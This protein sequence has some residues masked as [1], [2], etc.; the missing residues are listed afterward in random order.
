MSGRTLYI[1]DGYNVL[2]RWFPGVGKE[3]LF[4]RREWLV[5]RLAEL[6]AVR[7]ASALVVFDAP[8]AG[9]SVQRPLAR[10]DLEVAFAGGG[11]TA[12]TLIARRIAEQPA[13]VTVVVV[14]ADQEVQRAAARAGVV[15]MTPSELEAEVR[16][17]RDEARG[18]L[19]AQALDSASPSTRMPTRLEDKVDPETLRRLDELRRKPQ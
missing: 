2:H 18:G 1:V 16:A 5:D 4:A 11:F 6:V 3:E 15:R 13:D 14:S 17:L 12:D 8:A 19:G 10:L 7:G 9:V